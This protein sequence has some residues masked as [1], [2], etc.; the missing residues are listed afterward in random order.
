MLLEDED[1]WVGA[2]AG[3][4]REA[5]LMGFIETLSGEK[6]TYAELLLPTFTGW[7]DDLEE[8]LNNLFA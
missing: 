3:L 2:V 8:L 1:E 5:C 4:Q 6:R 7:P